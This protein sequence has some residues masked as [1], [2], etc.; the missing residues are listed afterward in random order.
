MF[1]RILHSLRSQ[2]VTV[3]FVEL[4]MII[5]G[6]VV[7]FQVDE[8][9]DRRSAAEEEHLWLEAV[10]EDLSQSVPFIQGRVAF[11]GQL[12]SG[13]DEVLNALN[14]GEIPASKKTTFE[15][16]LQMRFV[17]PTPF[18]LIGTIQQLNVS[19]QMN[20]IS[21]VELRRKLIGLVG[22]AAAYDKNITGIEESIRKVTNHPAELYRVDLDL[23]TGRPY[24]VSFNLEAMRADPQF[25]MDIIFV[26]NLHNLSKGANETFVNRVQETIDAIDDA[27]DPE[28]EEEE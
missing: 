4:L 23:A 20:D 7:A 26:R 9:K 3:A 13:L 18:Q 22:Y 25:K 17:T 10:R 15:R 19:G 2:S 28:P 8:W 24:V 21:N 11:E 12:I 5:V 1:Q 14:T 27:L 16:G 6:V